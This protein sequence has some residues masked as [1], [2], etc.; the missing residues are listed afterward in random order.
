MELK[1]V[2]TVSDVG[3][4]FIGKGIVCLLGDLEYSPSHF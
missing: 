1:E 2:G 3:E 4:A